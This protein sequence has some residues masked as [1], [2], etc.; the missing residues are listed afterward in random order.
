MAV[1]IFAMVSPALAQGSGSTKPPAES[2]ERPHA[3]TRLAEGTI[4]EIDR[5]SGA[6]VLETRDGRLDLSIDDET[7]FSGRADASF[8]NLVEGDRIRARYRTSGNVAVEIR[9]SQ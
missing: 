2:K 6:V 5:S 1:A 8:A 7:K 3:V 4:V 9:I